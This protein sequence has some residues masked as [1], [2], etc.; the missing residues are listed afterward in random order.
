M[1]DERVIP[2]RECPDHP[3]THPLWLQ[4]GAGTDAAWTCQQV[5]A[6]HRAALELIDAIGRRRAIALAPSDRSAVV[7]GRD[8]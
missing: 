4:L 6:S 8:R 5:G 7:R 2:W 1:E 3:A